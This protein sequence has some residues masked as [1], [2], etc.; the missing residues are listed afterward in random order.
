MNKLLSKRELSILVYGNN[1]LEELPSEIGNLENLKQLDLS[2]NLFNLHEGTKVKLVDDFGDDWVKIKIAN[3]D[4]GWIKINE[5]K[6][7]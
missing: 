1:R 5:I 2:D 3:G 4:E 7:I 6:I